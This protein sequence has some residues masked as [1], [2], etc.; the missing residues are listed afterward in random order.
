MSQFSVTEDSEIPFPAGA[1]SGSLSGQ[2][3]VTRGVNEI[4]RGRAEPA[5]QSPARHGP[6]DAARKALTAA[7]F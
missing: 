7:A 2:N 4:V 6:A 1:V 5:Q 3:L